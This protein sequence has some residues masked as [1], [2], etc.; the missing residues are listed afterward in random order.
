[1]KRVEQLEAELDFYQDMKPVA[2][3]VV[4]PQGGAL[5]FRNAV[6]HL[7]CTPLYEHPK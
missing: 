7:A 4:D 3:M 6:H 5:F 2:W 1:M